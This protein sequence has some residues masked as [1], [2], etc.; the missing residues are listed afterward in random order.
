MKTAVPSYAQRAPSIARGLAILVESSLGGDDA[1]LRLVPGPPLDGAPDRVSLG[2]GNLFALKSRFDGGLQ[3][4]LRDLGGV[5][6]V[7]VDTAAV[8]ELAV[9]VEDEEL[10]G[11]E[12]AEPQ[13][14]ALI[15]IEHVRERETVTGGEVRHAFRGVL[16]VGLEVVGVDADELHLAL[17]AL[18]ECDYPSHR[19]DHGRAVVADEGH[20]QHRVPVGG[21]SVVLSG[22]VGQFCVWKGCA[23]GEAVVL[24]GA[25]HAA[26]LAPKRP[27]WC[28]QY[29]GCIDKHQYI[30][31]CQC[32][33]ATAA[34]A[35]IFKALADEGRLRIL[36]FLATGDATCCSTGEGIC[37]CDVEA[38]VGLSQP[39]VSHHMKVLVEAGLVRAEKRGRWTYYEVDSRGLEAAQAFLGRFPTLS[40]IPG[41]RSAPQLIQMEVV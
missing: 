27:T 38:A 13:S 20:H 36:E 6:R 17:V 23:D 9:L 31:Y 24:E 11:T 7:V 14:D 5:L 22:R 3:V 2:S 25:S 40:P 26:M 33:N 1:R 10:G 41:R 32:V 12:C 19:S 15:A 28:G 21:E 39:T 37:G 34:P 18:G 30:D 35:Q 29:Q 8:P 16:R 4:G